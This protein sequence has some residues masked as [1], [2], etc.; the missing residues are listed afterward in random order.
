MKDICLVKADVSENRQFL[1]SIGSKFNW[2][3]TLYKTVG[4][5]VLKSEK[6][7]R[8][9]LSE[10]PGNM[11]KN[12]GESISTNENG[13]T[14]HVYLVGKITFIFEKT[15]FFFLIFFLLRNLFL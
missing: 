12:F 1:I 15:S 3:I 6:N 8:S 7:P 2:R 5:T 10:N 4:K 14:V 13:I 11:A 9:R